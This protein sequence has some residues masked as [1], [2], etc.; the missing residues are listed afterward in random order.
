[1][2]KEKEIFEKEQQQ[3]MNKNKEKAMLNKKRLER[4]KNELIKAYKKLNQNINLLRKTNLHLQTA[5]NLNF[6]MKEYLQAI[7]KADILA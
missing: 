6:S 3:K 5:N 1:M 4:Q 2:M 7:D